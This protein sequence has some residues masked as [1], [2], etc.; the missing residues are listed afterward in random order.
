[1]GK[2]KAPKKEQS[3][4]TALVHEHHKGGKKKCKGRVTMIVR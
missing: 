1:M 4:S 2:G 3:N